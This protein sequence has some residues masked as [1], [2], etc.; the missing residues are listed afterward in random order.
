MKKLF[1]MA[2]AV[3]ALSFAAC[4]NKAA[5]TEPAP[6]AEA[7]EVIEEVVAP[8]EEGLVAPEG[9]PAPAP[10]AAP[11]PEGEPAPAPAPGA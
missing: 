2:A 9:E 6:E 1:L 7:P 4:G 3:A 10:E 11:A 5:Q 8:V